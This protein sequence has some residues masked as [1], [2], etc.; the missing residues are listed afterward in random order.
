[1][2]LNIERLRSKLEH[3]KDPRKGSKERG[4][5]KTWTPKENTTSH[6]RLIQYPYSDDP[7]VELFFHYNIGSGGGILCPKSNY[8]KT[9]PICE[10]GYELYKKGDKVSSKLCFPRQRIYAAMV[11]RADPTLTPKLWGFG[12]EIYQTLIESLLKEDCGYFLDP[13]NGIDAEVTST[14]GPS[15]QFAKTKLTFSRK[16]SSL[17]A[18]DKQIQEIINAIPNLDDVFKPLSNAEINARIQEWLKLDENDGGETVKASSATATPEEVTSS[19][20]NIKD[21]DA[22]FEQAL[23]DE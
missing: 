14:K 5:R 13:K 4:E 12:K 1:M 15:E 21:L 23:K 8:G 7:F 6:I 3:L 16:D 11:D 20:E 9:C 18:S 17:A 22:A 19:N 2:S 10:L